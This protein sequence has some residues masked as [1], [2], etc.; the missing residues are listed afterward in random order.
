VDDVNSEPPRPPNN[1]SGTLCNTIITIMP[2]NEKQ[3]NSMLRYN[4]NVGVLRYPF[5]F[6]CTMSFPRQTM[7]MMKKEDFAISFHGNLTVDAL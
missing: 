2:T 3:I 5:P 4:V 7:T 1:M 6:D